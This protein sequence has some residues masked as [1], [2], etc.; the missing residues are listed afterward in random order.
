MSAVPTHIYL[1]K[2]EIRRYTFAF[3]ILQS[4]IVKKLFFYLLF[5]YIC[6]S[7]IISLSLFFSFF[8]GFF[9]GGGGVQK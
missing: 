8:F 5:L 7:I 3:L 9:W 1:L 2:M 6:A 4:Y